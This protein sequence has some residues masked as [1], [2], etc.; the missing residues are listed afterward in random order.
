MK[1]IEESG[2]GSHV[3]PKTKYNE[4]RRFFPVTVDN[5]F[6]N[7]DKIVNYAKS[8]PKTPNSKG[9]WPGKRTEELWK[10]DNE[11][12]NAILLKI[13]SCYYDLSYQDVTWKRSNLAFQEI[14]AF[15][16]NKNDVRNRGWIHFDDSKWEVAGLI[17]LTPD[18]D[19]DSGTSLF[20]LNRRYDKEFMAYKKQFVKHLFY[21]EDETIDKDYYAKKIKEE[22]KFFIEKVRFAN[23]YNRMI[24]YDAN[25]F[26]RANSFYNKNG[27]P[28]R[29]TLVFF[30]GGLD[31]GMYPLEKIREKN[32]NE[33]IEYQIMKEMTTDQQPTEQRK[34]EYLSSTKII[35]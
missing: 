7:P 9:E 23:I 29:L 22:E 1:M 24:M 33:F 15:S 35:N 3:A 6:D 30:I 27:K 25:E 19:P 26:H 4:I 32:C 11:L 21:K 28:A 31:A 34:M 14:P 16:E 17:Y 13:L 8:L 20:T 12:S 10:I 5:F 18:I 2:G